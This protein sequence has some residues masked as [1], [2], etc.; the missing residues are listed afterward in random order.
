MTETDPS[1]DQRISAGELGEYSFWLARR[2]LV[3]LT[4]GVGG[5]LAVSGALS[6]LLAMD[7]SVDCVG[8]IETHRT[9]HVKCETNGIVEDVTVKYGQRIEEGAVVA[10]LDRREVNARLHQ[11]ASDLVENEERRAAITEEIAREQ[12]QTRARVAQLEL[13][14]VGA[15]MVLDRIR[16]ELELQR[17][18]LVLGEGRSRRAV[19]ELIPIREAT[20]L[21][22]Q[23]SLELSMS[24]QRLHGPSSRHHEVRALELAHDK[25][26]EEKSLLEHQL[27]NSIVRAPTSGRVITSRPA[28]R[29][30]D[31]VRTGESIVELDAMEGWEARVVVDERDLPKIRL[32]HRARVFIE[33]FPH[34]E[35]RIF[36]GRVTRISSTP[37]PDGFAIS[38]EI[39]NPVV[40][41]A[42]EEFSLAHGM[43]ATV[44]IVVERGRIAGILFRKLLGGLNGMS[45]KVRSFGT[46]GEST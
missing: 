33:A 43:K 27:L 30:G 32:G 22:R 20:L 26:R 9:L 16:M 3:V 31:Y 2:L 15:Q 19:D 40:S 11:T 38:L 45:Q 23:K 29:I 44:Q 17:D 36:E 25:L 41:E 39:A 7:V 18:D 14:L 10:L 8:A 24:R 35:Y 42:A 34:L 46:H 13:E 28:R 6:Y 1:Q 4:A 5:I 12:W 21:V 37:G